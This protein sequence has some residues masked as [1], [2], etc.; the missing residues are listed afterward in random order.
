M[1]KYVLVVGG[2]K[3]GYYLADTLKRNGYL[4]GVVEADAERARKI[5]DDLDISVIAGDATEPAILEDANASQARYVVALTGSDESNLAICQMAKR[6]FGVPETIARAINP[7]NEAVFKRLGIDATI[8]TTAMAAETIE[9]VL[10]ANGM[11]LS[12]IFSQGDVEMAEVEITE[13]S[14]VLGKALAEVG[15]PGDCLLIAVI[16]DGTVAFPRGRTVFRGGDRVYALTRRSNE[17]E[18]R[19]ALMGGAR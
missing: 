14:R 19:E 11:R 3:V 10:P 7:K 5:A 2:G 17:D 6:E 9:K 15:L 16:R 1:K 8:S 13:K 4:V 12:P 18:L